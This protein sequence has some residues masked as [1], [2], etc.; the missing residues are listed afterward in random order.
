MDLVPNETM[1]DLDIPTIPMSPSSIVL[2]AAAK[3]YELKNIH[4]NMMPSF[5]G[6]SFE[7]HLAH[8][9]DIFNI[10]SNMALTGGVTEEHLMMI[11][12][13]NTLKDKAKTWLNF[14]RPGLLTSWMEVQNKFLEKFFTTQKTNALR[15]KI[16]Q[17]S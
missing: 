10:V 4:F 8:I 15:D 9:R 13:P 2:P 5:H 7:D 3:Y 6:L 12:F 14:L 1:G 17:F 16:M 11:V